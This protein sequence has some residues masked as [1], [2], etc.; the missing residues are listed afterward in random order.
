M[1][2]ESLNQFRE[3]LSADTELQ[4]A[5]RGLLGSDGMLDLAAAVAL[6][7]QHGFQFTA[8]DITSAASND[9]DELSDFELEMV[10]AGAPL[11]SGNDGL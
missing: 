2:I 9:N 6:G 7:E 8:E 4:E 3:K 10:S 5:M 1:T 11:Q